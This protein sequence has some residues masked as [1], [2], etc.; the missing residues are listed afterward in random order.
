MPGLELFFKLLVAHATADFVLQSE[1]M[2]RGKNRHSDIHHGK[3][4]NFPKW[5]YWLTAHALVHGGLVYLVTNSLL[6]GVIETV[7]HWCIDFA[8]CEGLIGFHQDQALHVGFK[9]GYVFA[10]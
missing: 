10:V 5:Y 4:F 7:S 9:I 6:L 2:G 8:K 1:A 3:T